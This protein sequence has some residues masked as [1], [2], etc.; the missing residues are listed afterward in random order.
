MASSQDPKATEQDAAATPAK[1]DLA[2][3]LVQQLIAFCIDGKGPLR[4]AQAVADKALAKHPEAEDA[5]KSVV[6][7]SGQ[8]GLAGGFVTGVGGLFTL[9]V[10]LPANVVEFYITAT[11]MVAAIAAL[12]GYDLSKPQTRTAVLLCLT[13]SRNDDLLAK[14]GLATPNLALGVVMDRLPEAALMVVNKG[15]GFRLLAKLS[16]KWLVKLGKFVPLA[17]GVIG[18]GMDW[19]LLR[20]IA[21]LAK[22]EFPQ[23]PIGELHQAG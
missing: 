7:H 9:P 20:R 22:K 18:G 2:T 10:S 3:R 8:I 12:R 16:S 1:S 13:G 11:R 19:F 21:S 23:R 5:I 4:T 15:L 14:T 6:A 17:G